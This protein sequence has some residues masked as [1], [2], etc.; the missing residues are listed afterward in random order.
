MRDMAFVAGGAAIVSAAN[1]A[2]PLAGAALGAACVAEASREL[3]RRA[4]CRAATTPQPAPAHVLRACDR[5]LAARRFTGSDAASSECATW[6]AWLPWESLNRGEKVTVPDALPHPIA[7]GFRPTRRASDVGQDVD[8]ARRL[9]DGSRLHVHGFNAG[10]TRFVVHRDRL[11][12]DGA[13]AVAVR[14]HG[15]TRFVVHR[16]RLD[17]DGADAVA[18]AHWISETP[19]GRAL[20]AATLVASL[21]ALAYW[22]VTL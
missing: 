9:A 6:C 21:G 2:W 3:D 18:V 11:D 1:A 17:P 5:A 10:S 22:T 19:E 20:G 4:E 15:G 7:A 16:D 13:D 12:P 14:N 8:L